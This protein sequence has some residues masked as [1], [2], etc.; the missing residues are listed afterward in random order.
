MD[1]ARGELIGDEEMWLEIS[2]LQVSLVVEISEG[3]AESCL[4]N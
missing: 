4:M 2:L 3:F 1:D